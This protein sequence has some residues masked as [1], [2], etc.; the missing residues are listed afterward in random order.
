VSVGS[1]GSTGNSSDV[2]SGS[3]TFESRPGY[4]L[5]WRGFIQSLEANFGVVPQI[6]GA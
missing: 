6:R 2:Y 4:G 5:S 3:V 1:G